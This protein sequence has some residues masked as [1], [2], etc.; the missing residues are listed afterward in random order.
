M[1]F[2]DLTRMKNQ[3]KGQRTNKKYKGKEK[4][5]NP[6]QTIGKKELKFAPVSRNA[7]YATYNTVKDAFLLKLQEEKFRSM[8]Y[9]VKAM[10]EEKEP[11]WEDMRPDKMFSSFD[12]ETETFRKETLE[13][14]TIRI[15]VENEEDAQKKTPEARKKKLAGNVRETIK[16]VQDLYDK[17]WDLEMRQWQETKRDYTNEVLTVY[18]ILWTKFMSPVMQRRIEQESDYLTNIHNNPVE[19]LKRV[20]AQINENTYSVHPMISF[21]GSLKRFFDSQQQT[22]QSVQEYWKQFKASQDVVEAQGGVNMFTHFVTLHNKQDIEEI[23]QDANLSMPE[24]K[25]KIAKILK[26]G[27]EEMYAHLFMLGADN[28]KYGSL[29]KNLRSEYGREQ[30]NGEVYPKTLE[31]AIKTLNTHSWDQAYYDNKKKQKSKDTKPKEQETSNSSATSFAQK[32]KEVICY[33]CGTVG[34]TKPQCTKDI[35]KSEWWITK[36]ASQQ[37][38]VQQGSGGNDNGSTAGESTGGATNPQSGGSG[39]TQGQ[40][41]QQQQLQQSQHQLSQQRAG[42]VP[43]RGVTSFQAQNTGRM[44]FQQSGGGYCQPCNLGQTKQDNYDLMRLILLD[45]GSSIAASIANEEM[46]HNYRPCKE[47]LTMATNAGQTLLDTAADMPGWG[48]VYFNKDGM[49][50]IFGLY[51][52]TQKYRVTMDS[53]IKNAIIVHHPNGPIEFKC[54]EEGL[55]A[56]NPDEKFFEEVAAK[57]A[58]EPKNTFQALETVK[59]NMQGYTQKE[60]KGARAAKD[61]YRHF[62]CPGYEAFKSLLK[63]NVIQDCPVTVQ[64]AINAEKIFGP[65]V[66]LLKGKSRRPKQAA[67]KNEWIEV[68]RE[69]YEKHPDLDL[70]I[71]VIYVN[72]L[73]H[74]TSIDGVIRFRA[75]VPLDSRSAE[76]LYKALD[77]ILRHY[78]KA[79]FVISEIHADSEFDPMITPLEDNLHIDFVPYGQGEHVKKAERNNQTIAGNIRAIFHSLPYKAYPKVMTKYATMIAA[80]NFNHFPAKGG[81]SPYYSPHVILGKKPLNYKKHCKHNFGSYVQGFHENNPTNTQHQR[82]VCGIYLRPVPNSLTSHEIMNLETGRVNKVVKVT[83]LPIT[84]HVIAAVNAMA[85]EQDVKKLKIESRNKIPLYPADWIAGVDN[86]P[87]EI[88]LDDDDDDSQDRD[89]QA[90][91]DA[92]YEYEREVNNEDK[93]EPIDDEELDELLADEDAVD[94]RVEEDDE[95]LPPPLIQK[96]EIS[97]AESEDSDDEEEEAEEANPTNSTQGIEITGVQ[98]QTAEENTDTAASPRPTRN[99]QPPVRTTYAKFGSPLKHKKNYLQKLSFQ[100]L[101]RKHNVLTQVTPN[102][103][104]DLGYEPHE[105]MVLARYIHHLDTDCGTGV[106]FGQQYIYERG[107]KVFGDRAKKGGHKELKQLNDRDVFTPRLISELTKEEKE[108][109]QEA[110][111]L[112][113]EKKDSEVKGRLCYN[114]KETR[115]WHDKDESHSPTVSNEGLT[116]TMAID[117]KEGRDKMSCDVPNAFVQTPMPKVEIGKRVIMKVKGSLVKLLVELDPAKFES[118]VVIEDGKPVLYLE[119]NKAIYGMLIAA[120]LWYKKLRG[121]LES[122][123]FVFNSYEPCICNRDIDGKQHTVRFHVDDMMSSHMDSKV[124]DEFLIWLNKMYGEYS[125]VKFTRGEIHDFLGVVYDF[126]EPGKV[127]VDMVDYV[128]QMLNDFSV[129]FSENDKVANP[130]ATNLFDVGTGAPL[131]MV[132]KKEFH[133]FVAKGLFLCNRAR[134]DIKQVIALLC[135][136][137][138]APNQDDWDKLVRLMLFLHTTKLDCLILTVDDLHVIKWWIDVSF[139]VHPD[140]KSHTGA[141]MSMGSGALISGSQKQKLNTRSSTEGEF[142]GVDDVIAKVLWTRLFLEEQGYEIEKNVLYQDNKSAILLEKNGKRSSGKRTR[143]INIRYFFVT[144][145]IEKGLVSVEYCPTGEMIADYLTKP[146]QGK[147]FEKFRNLIMGYESV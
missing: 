137:V 124:N 65:D 58:T 147:L 102:S 104:W 120:L 50:N 31:Q 51:A 14:K 95:S 112:V 7:N 52:M 25:E 128:Q 32:M 76:D 55:Y 108:R 146:L 41:G 99:V 93:F 59:E 1:N 44:L 17:E 130:A 122:I 145:Q 140:F 90:P 87:I 113:T 10:S 85:E 119:V 37:Q 21:I 89:Y 114:G 42:Y 100:A 20:K 110:I 46:A 75:A 138:K 121:D 23:N 66:G 26:K 101:E 5:S 86:Q 84:D 64:D 82:T 8:A 118:F 136:R 39:W 48:E 96:D 4:Q 40:Q 18:S 88:N 49:A 24:K 36:Q 47:P 43:R 109:A 117:A 116:L 45:S 135:T 97:V 34:H 129:E 133:T 105:A 92:R 6:N 67:Q 115:I 62:Q 56:F 98:E 125:D 27:M 22:D 94:F 127:K 106:S 9:I 107:L 53:A 30:N 80:A 70:H 144:D 73:P 16:Q 71:D 141:V 15:Q 2:E 61:L 60:I 69:I 38:H 142:V 3:G 68:P 83:D 134:P 139:A 103:D 78:N 72:E 131:D 57:K 123:G 35:P 91:K 63:T 19:C 132:Q 54:T 74:L 33:I 111:L 126:T 11:K 79:D 81:V 12:P 77:A 13:E 28:L 29:K 143:A